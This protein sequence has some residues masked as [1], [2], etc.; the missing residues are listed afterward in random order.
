MRT[1]V[2]GN[3]LS[4]PDTSGALFRVPSGIGVA[5]IHRSA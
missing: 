3:S 1:K 5:P 2:K 4:G